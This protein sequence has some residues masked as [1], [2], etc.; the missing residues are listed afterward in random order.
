MTQIS[1][2]G[3]ISKYFETK[4]RF[5]LNCFFYNKVSFPFDPPFMERTFV[6]FRSSK[7]RFESP[8]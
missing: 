1:D 7:I 4:F 2:D 3:K 8:T 6:L 5:V